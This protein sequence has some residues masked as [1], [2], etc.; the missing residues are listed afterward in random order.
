MNVVGLLICGLIILYT[1]KKLSFYGD[2]IA[3][4]TGITKAMI[5]FFLMAAVTSL[6]ELMVG[7]SS[8][9]IV[10]SADFAVGDILGS[11]A[12]NLL[13]LSIMDG[14]PNQKQSLLAI[15][16]QSHILAASMGVFLF[17]LV[18]LGIYLDK[19]FQLLPFI[20]LNSI[21]F[22]V[23]FFIA[24]RI[25][26]NYQRSQPAVVHE[27]VKGV[28]FTLKQILIR[29]SIFA[30][31]TVGAA[32]FL[33]YF[34]EGLA[35]QTGME[36]SFVGTLFL[37]IST[38]FPEIAVSIAAIRMNSVDLAVGNILGSNIF[39]IFILFIDDLFY[40]KGSLLADA[41]NNHLVSVFSIIMM[42]A[43]VIVA[44]AY[45][46]NSKKY[47]LSFDTYLILLI[48]LASISIL[49]FI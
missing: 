14:Y 42:S 3:I 1:G 47:F 28:D 37:A 36:R 13:I 21:I 38:S 2:L 33:P 9:T 16:S 34:A 19:D 15:V 8:S 5:G 23:I 7:I 25:M 40:T 26:F 22:V 27:E 4:K 24:M 31:I 6:P 46:H 11:C 18:G 30:L 49:Y 39:N 17:A 44:I 20:G 48:Y 35:E 32:L 12:F 10:V 29:Y 41:S 45:R 43:V